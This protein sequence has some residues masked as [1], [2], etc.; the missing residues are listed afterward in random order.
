VG[1]KAFTPEY[2]WH[3]AKKATYAWLILLVIAVIFV[4]CAMIFNSIRLP[5]SIIGIIP[6][7]FIGIFLAFGLFGFPF[8]Q[9]GFASFVMV[10]G[11]VVNAG[12]Y[13]IVAYSSDKG[14]RNPVGK[15]V[16]AFNHKI[17][18]ITLTIISTILGLIPFLFDGPSEVFWFAFAVGTISGL[19]FSIISVVFYLPVFMLKKH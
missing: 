10:A 8:D 3:G 15:F 9:G 2:Y 1:Y 6:V 18:P 13:L 19:L 12:I 5:L 7:S 16:K 11:L 17:V 4:I 14:G